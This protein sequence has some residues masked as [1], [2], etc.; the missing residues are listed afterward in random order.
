ASGRP[1]LAADLDALARRHDAAE[2]VP[3]LA[4]ETLLR[5]AGLVGAGV[6]AL[7]AV[8]P[9]AVRMLSAV[10]APVV[11]VGTSTWDPGWSVEVP[12]QTVA[13]APTLDERTALWNRALAGSAPLDPDGA[14]AQFVLGPAQVS[15][16]VRSAKAAALLGDGEVG[17]EELRR[18]A[19][20]QN[21]AGLERLARRIEPQVD[22][23]EDR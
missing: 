12:L 8:A 13:V 20:A 14:T 10:P 22:W 9:E 18:G 16:A 21:A 23:A 4:R 15:R 6:D 2:L 5:G 17:A 19:R 11:L 1:V 7:A 3:V